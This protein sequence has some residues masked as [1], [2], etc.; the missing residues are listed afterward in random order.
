MGSE[1]FSEMWAPERKQRR[2]WASGSNACCIPG[3]LPGQP[4]SALGRDGRASREPG[5]ASFLWAGKV[6]AK[7]STNDDL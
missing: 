2:N 4:L 1:S 3:F 5:R 6:F 7:L